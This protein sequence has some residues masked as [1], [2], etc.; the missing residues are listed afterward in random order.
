M[1]H[2]SSAAEGASLQPLQIDSDSAF[3]KVKTKKPT[4]VLAKLTPSK[5]QRS[6][7]RCQEKSVINTQP[8]M[9]EAS[10]FSFRLPVE[11]LRNLKEEDDFQVCL[12]CEWCQQ[13]PAPRRIQH[14]RFT[15]HPNLLLSLK[16]R[17][18]RAAWPR[19]PRG[20]LFRKAL[21]TLVSP[22]S[23]QKT[24]YPSTA[25]SGHINHSKPW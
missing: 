8:V 10:V 19:R 14:W 7:R 18:C 3:W 2:L 6:D 21:I 20:V 22:A 23:S 25:A 5:E 16:Y 24:I 1:S 17:Q 15:R 12:K 9:P 13:P 4:P 11:A